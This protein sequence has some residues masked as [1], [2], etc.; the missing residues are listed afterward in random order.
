MWNIL[1][2]YLE[3]DSLYADPKDVDENF[4]KMQHGTWLY[5]EISHFATNT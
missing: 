3:I 5:V 2:Q 1:T 4:A